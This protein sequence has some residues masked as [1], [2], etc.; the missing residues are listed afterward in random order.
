MNKQQYLL[1][2]TAHKHKLPLHQISSIIFDFF[3]Q[4]TKSL[5]ENKEVTIPHFGKFI[6]TIKE[7]Y[8]GINPKTQEKVK[9]PA[10]RKIKFNMHSQLKTSLNATKI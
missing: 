6:P 3:D 5:V 9:V 7:S 2:N 10:R 1:K 4:L 8:M